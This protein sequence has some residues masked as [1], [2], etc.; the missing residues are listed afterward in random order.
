MSHFGDLMR[1]SG[2]SLFLSDCQGLESVHSALR[3]SDIRHQCHI[4]NAQGTKLHEEMS[5]RSVAFHNSRT[6]GFIMPPHLV[7]PDL[8][9]EESHEENSNADAQDVACE[10]EENNEMNIDPP[11]F[12]G[13]PLEAENPNDLL[14]RLEPDLVGDDDEEVEEEVAEPSRDAEVMA[15]EENMK[16]KVNR[17]LNGGG[18]PI[19]T[20]Q[21]VFEHIEEKKLG[22]RSRDL[23]AGDGNCF[24]SSILD[25]AKKFEIPGIPNDTHLL[26]LQITDA[27]KEHPRFLHWIQFYFDGDFELFER[28]AELLR[29]NS[30]FTDNMG[31]TTATAAHMIGN[32]LL[33][34]LAVVMDK[35]LNSHSLL[36][37]Y[38]PA[39]LG[40]Q[41]QD[42]KDLLDLPSYRVMNC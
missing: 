30:Q 28:T 25:L 4:T 35:P 15:T 17:I 41:K 5:I 9:P 19:Y 34:R 23:I 10:D 38:G 18:G 13:D 12:T 20:L 7:P 36:S 31:L 22:L 32:K 40:S 6:L 11:G 3:K 26:R 39:C 42:Q 24:Y 14:A 8:D 16:Q 27:M 29:Q 21:Q 2:R 37:Q 1:E 33:C